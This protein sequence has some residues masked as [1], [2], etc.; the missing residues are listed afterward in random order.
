VP[1]DPI[2]A[3]SSRPSPEGVLGAALAWW[4]RPKAQPAGRPAT[5][6]PAVVPPPAGLAAVD[7]LPTD[8]TRTWL[9]PPY[10]ANRLQDWRLSRGRLECVAASGP[11]RTRTVAVLTRELVG[12]A[13][14]G[15]I[16]LVS[17]SAEADGGARHWFA[18]L[19]TAGAK[20]AER[21]ERAE[22]LVL[23]AL[24]TLNGPVLKL[25][26]Q[27]F[28][29]GDGDPPEV[30]LQ[31]RREGGGWED[32]GVAPVG[33]GF[34]AAFR[35]PDWDAGAERRY[36]VL[37]GAGTAEEQAF[38]GDRGRRP[39]RRRR[40]AGRAAGL[41]HPQ[42]PAPERGQRRPR[43]AGR[44]APAGAVHRA[45][46]LLPLR[47]AGRRAPPPPPAAAG[48]R[49][50]PVLRAPAD[51]Q[52]ARPRAHPGRAV[53]LVP[54]AVGV[55]R[56]DPLGAHGGAGRRPRR[57]PPQPVGQRRRPAPGGDYR[58][59]GYIHPAAWVNLVQRI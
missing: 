16:A 57:L 11:M 26:T 58:Q 29:I 20:A 50:R 31:T 8:R 28:P 41:R 30:R 47:Q 9:G 2:V 44:V 54:V 40:A 17:S 45:Q 53:P 33:P 19:G 59:G 1:A 48:R 10:W 3:S 22:G 4:L 23:G 14:T 37:W 43:P 34:A 35:I 55:P 13:L 6:P 7:R 56:P 18:G 51:H 27:L 46:P 21:P 36:R 25:T 24:Y 42:L 12:A 52:G 39:G 15:G 49:G 32:A 5:S 38:E